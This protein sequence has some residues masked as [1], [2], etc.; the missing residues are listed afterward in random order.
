MYY[1]T[2]GK[3]DKISNELMDKAIVF[4]S[5]FLDIDETIEVDFEDEFEEDRCGYCD[6]DEDGVTVFINPNMKKSQIL[7]TLFHEM[8]HAKQFVLGELIPGEGKNPSRWMGKE[9]DVPYLETPWEREAYEYETAMWDIFR[10]ET[11]WLTL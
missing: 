8:V 5:E 3:P 4:A 2:Y 9:Y 6:Y 7:I 1:V 10:K 11:N